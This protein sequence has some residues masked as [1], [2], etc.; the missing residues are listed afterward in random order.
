MPLLGAPAS[1]GSCCGASA[2]KKHT[3]RLVGEYSCS[4]NTR[5]LANA[6]AYLIPASGSVLCVLCLVPA[7]ALLCLL[8]VLQ[9]ADLGARAVCVRKVLGKVG[10]GLRAVLLG[11][12]EPLLYRGD[13]VR[14]AA[15]ASRAPQKARALLNV[16]AEAVVLQ[17]KSLRLP[18]GVE[19]SAIPVPS[20][21]RMCK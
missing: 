2:A 6:D 4:I 19:L 10:A 7:L 13:R 1:G 17:G 8:C 20:R 18:V 11:S 21:P 3:F 9:A 12:T 15:R 5:G 16:V 14:R